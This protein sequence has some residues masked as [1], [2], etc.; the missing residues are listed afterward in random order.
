MYLIDDPS[1]SVLSET[2]LQL[3]LE[4]LV[5]LCHSRQAPEG[6]IA[7][8]EAL[9]MKHDLLTGERIPGSNSLSNLNNPISAGPSLH[10]HS[11]VTQARDF[12]DPPA[13]QE[14]TEVL[15]REWINM[16]HSPSAGQGSASAFQHFVKQMNL[17]GILKTDDLITRF[18][19]ICISMCRDLCVRSILEQGQG[20]SPTYVRSKCFQNLDAFVRLIAL[21]V[22][23]SGEATNP[24]T[25]INLLNKVL[26]LVCGIM[27]HD[28]ESNSTDFQQLPYHRILIMLFLELNAPETILESINLPVCEVSSYH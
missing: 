23:H 1:N 22:K 3:T 13:L 8:I 15:L 17:H 16:Y 2:D 4:A 21:L 27:I 28:I 25:K 10:F 26:G 20:P 14:K 18:F 12:Q 11:G 24:T 19:R 5:R 7:L 9:R 6:L